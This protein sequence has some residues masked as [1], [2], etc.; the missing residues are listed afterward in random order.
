MELGDEYEANWS[1]VQ[2]ASGS[3]AVLRESHHRDRGHA[4]VI[5]A[6]TGLCTLST[7]P[8][9]DISVIGYPSLCVLACP[10]AMHRPLCTVA[11]CPAF[12]LF[13]VGSQRAADRSCRWASGCRTLWRE[14]SYAW[15]VA[16]RYAASRSR[17]LWVLSPL[18]RSG[19]GVRLGNR[20]VGSRRWR[21]QGGR[22]LRLRTGFRRQKPFR[23]WSEIYQVIN[24]NRAHGRAINMP[25]SHL[26][27][28]GSLTYAGWA[29]RQRRRCR[30]VPSRER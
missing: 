21:N 15:L 14:P 19:L 1:E 23:C 10:T 28:C 25:T 7:G 22:L 6:A 24:Q 27:N 4:A 26:Q 11:T 18:P 20:Q 5:A 13:W 16:L 30:G 2:T 12:R 17:R 8:A 3:I 29:T 9:A